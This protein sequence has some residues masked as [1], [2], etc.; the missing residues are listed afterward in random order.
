MISKKRI[1]LYP[2]F[3]EYTRLFFLSLS[4][5]ATNVYAFFLLVA[6]KLFLMP[7]AKLLVFVDTRAARISGMIVLEELCW[8]CPCENIRIETH[9]QSLY[10]PC[11]Y[12]EEIP[13]PGWLP[14]YSQLFEMHLFRSSRS[15]PVLPFVPY[16]TPFIF[17]VICYT[18]RQRY[19]C[20]MCSFA[21]VSC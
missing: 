9:H 15:F 20:M 21:A 16:V 13:T 11:R 3:R 12:H 18:G 2:L 19:W 1:Q 6:S 7:L 8:C 17:R 5:S 10:S 4:F 14:R